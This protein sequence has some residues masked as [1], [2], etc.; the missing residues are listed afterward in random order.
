ML[1][2]L[3]LGKSSS[4]MHALLSETYGT[5]AVLKSNVFKWH[6]SFREGQENVD[7]IERNGHLGTHRSNK[8]VEKMWYLLCLDKSSQ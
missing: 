1:N 5:E 6:K 3:K 8:N 7:D 2:F 4:E